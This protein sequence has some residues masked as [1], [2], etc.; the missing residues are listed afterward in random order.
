MKLLGALLLVFGL[1]AAAAGIAGIGQPDAHD[2]GPAVVEQAHQEPTA[3]T[4][5]TLV[6]A[7]LAGLSIAGGGAL[8][9]LGMGHFRRPRKIVPPNSPDE[10][11]AATTR[12][13]TF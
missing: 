5:G 13:T 2:S 1:I 7:V 12:P 4:G 8:I 3:E 10:S 9:G 11:R 6:L